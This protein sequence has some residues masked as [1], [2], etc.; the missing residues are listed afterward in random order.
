MRKPPRGA[1]HS[2]CAVHVPH[3]YPTS[4]Y[5]CMD[6][7]DL[8]PDMVSFADHLAYVAQQH[9]LA[10]TARQ[11]LPTK[12]WRQA[13]RVLCEQFEREW[14]VEQAARKA[15]REGQTA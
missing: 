8:V 4:G 10:E 5:L 7:P 12:A 9:H 11:A 3:P 1:K 2:R 15:R 6:S 14:P 13:W